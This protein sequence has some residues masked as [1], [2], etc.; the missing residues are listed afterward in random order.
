MIKISLFHNW[1]PSWP[2]FQHKIWK[3]TWYSD[4]LGS[5]DSHIPFL[6]FSNFFTCSFCLLK[7]SLS[8]S[9][10]LSLYLNISFCLCLS[11]FLSFSL[12]LSLSLFL[13]SLSVCVRVCLHTY[14]LVRV[15]FHFLTPSR[16]FHLKVQTRFVSHQK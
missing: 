5:W 15:G 14:C 11:P 9:I 1:P 12:S 2:T 16:V 3:V 13:I 7:K 10:S 8:L 6:S 4:R